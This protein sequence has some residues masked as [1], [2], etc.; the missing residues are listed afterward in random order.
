[1]LTHLLVLILAATDPT[2]A[3]TDTPP[4]IK[5]YALDC[6]HARFPDLAPFSDTGD[7]DGKSGEFIS[8]CFLI[9]HPTKGDFLWEAGMGDAMAGKGPQ[10]LGWV[11]FEVPTT[12]LAQLKQLGMTGYDDI[13]LF[14]FSHAHLD[15]TGNANALTK[16]T[17]LVPPR[18]LAWVKETKGQHPELLSNVTKVKKVEV[19]GDYDVFGDGSVRMLRAPGHT[20]DHHVLLV[21]LPKS[22]YVILAG[23]LAHQHE[24][25]E[26]NR[27]PAFNVSRADTLASIDRVK[28]I[29]SKLSAK[30]VSEHDLK[31]FNGLPK[32][33]AA[34]E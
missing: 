27:V 20:P 10:S 5:L 33:P 24:S 3:K 19:D 23:D 9:R 11:S 8:P 16:A 18:E 26:M 21:H 12:L 29:A 32:F 25:Y 13:E 15:H 2:T 4:A 14:A 7:Y 1:M 31:D 6:G 34:L 17:W 22:G 28:R 30:V